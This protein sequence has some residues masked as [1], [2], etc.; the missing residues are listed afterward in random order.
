[1]NNKNSIKR[2]NNE[3]I[4]NEGYNN[5]CVFINSFALCVSTQVRNFVTKTNKVDTF[6]A[7]ISKSSDCLGIKN[8]DF[9]FEGDAFTRTILNGYRERDG[10]IQLLNFNFWKKGSKRKYNYNIPLHK[11]TFAGY[12]GILEMRRQL[13]K[14]N[15]GKM[16]YP[17]V[18]K[19]KMK[20]IQLLF[21]NLAIVKAGSTDKYKEVLKDL[22]SYYLKERDLFF[23]VYLPTPTMHRVE[24]K[25]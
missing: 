23:P 11:F 16:P 2:K 18:S 13:W 15:N 3:K 4:R 17:R 10:I 7:N 22:G 24:K 14:K 20:D 6:R 21:L 5:N 12:L 1:M 19:V 8:S 25:S 9:D